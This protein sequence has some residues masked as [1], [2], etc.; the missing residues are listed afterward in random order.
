VFV[1]RKL[2]H[3]ISSD[4]LPQSAYVASRA[5]NALDADCETSLVTAWHPAEPHL[6]D[7][8]WILDALLLS[9]GQPNLGCFP[10][11]RTRTAAG[12]LLLLPTRTG[13]PPHTRG[14]NK[15]WSPLG[16]KTATAMASPL[17]NLIHHTDATHSVFTPATTSFGAHGSLGPPPS[18]QAP[19]APMAA[20][21]PLTIPNSTG[22]P[23][24]AASQGPRSHSTTQSLYQCADC[25][26]A[27]PVRTINT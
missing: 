9:T 6:T 22:S 4:I 27:S 18:N 14:A 23:A 15:T 13:S 25:L 16:I 21:P 7:N 2:V 24:A 20:S 26:S 19:L 1:L 8:N 5:T 11:P 3:S 12:L 17:A 10:S